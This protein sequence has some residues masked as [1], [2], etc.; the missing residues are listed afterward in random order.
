MSA[1]EDFESAQAQGLRADGQ[2]YMDWDI[3]VEEQTPDSAL[4]RS[5][6]D[7]APVTLVDESG[8]AAAEI[9]AW[10]DAQ[11]AWTIQ[12]QADGVWL[13]IQGQQL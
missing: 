9:D 5:T 2:R 1:Y 7:F 12:R 11:F 13:I 3:V 6:V 8:Q 4:L 10:P